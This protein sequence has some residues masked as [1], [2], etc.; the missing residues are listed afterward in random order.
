MTAVNLFLEI[1]DSFNMLNEFQLFMGFHLAQG[2]VY[3]IVQTISIVTFLNKRV[4][5]AK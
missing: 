3:W 1:S 4:I 5:A 2:K